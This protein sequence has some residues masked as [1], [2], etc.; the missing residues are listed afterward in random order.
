V[1][2]ASARTMKQGREYDNISNSTQNNNV[3]SLQMQTD[4]LPMF[5]PPSSNM[6]DPMYN[7]EVQPPPQYSPYG[8]NPPSY[9]PNVAYYGPPPGVVTTI[10]T[11][12][13]TYYEPVNQPGVAHAQ[14]E[15]EY[16]I[17]Q[18]FQEEQ[19]AIENP[20]LVTHQ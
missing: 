16:P 6:V 18:P 11:T 20:Y 15:P 3:I 4:N 14:Q 8:M 19:T 9:D 5:A 2:N 10:T 13:T 12:T 7:I 17:Q 1:M